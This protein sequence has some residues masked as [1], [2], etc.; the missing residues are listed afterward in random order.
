MKESRINFRTTQMNLLSAK[1][2]IDIKESK[3]A[4][5]SR[6]IT[7]KINEEKKKTKT[8]NSQI[9][10][11]EKDNQNL[12][13]QINKLQSDITDLKHVKKGLVTKIEDEKKATIKIKEET[14]MEEIRLTLLK[15]Q[16]EDESKS[17][18]LKNSEMS[19][20]KIKQKIF[21]Q[22]S[23]SREEKSANLK[24]ELEKEEVALRKSTRTQQALDEK[25]KRFADLE[26]Y[27]LYNLF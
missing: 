9:L 17:I 22:G 23:Q 18:K 26:F 15:E 8:D 20:L 4:L 7:R 2:Q 12:K 16:N 25:S 27:L 19:E 6:S 1:D 13:E 10:D 24:N 3:N 5:L 11:R 14:K 21:E